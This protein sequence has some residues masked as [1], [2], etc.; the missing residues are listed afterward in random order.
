MKEFSHTAR[1]MASG[2]LSSDPNFSYE[3]PF[4]VP[5]LLVRVTFLECE[6][7]ITEFDRSKKATYS[8]YLLVFRAMPDDIYVIVL[9][10]RPD[11]DFKRPVFFNIKK[12][13]IMALVDVVVPAPFTR[14]QNIQPL[15]FSIEPFLNRHSK[16]YSLLPDSPSAFS[17]ANKLDGEFSIVGMDTCSSLL[18]PNFKF[19]PLIHRFKIEFRE[20]FFVRTEIKRLYSYFFRMMKMILSFYPFSRSLFNLIFPTNDGTGALSHG[21]P[22]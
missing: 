10:Q 8:P 6:T 1:I 19:W 15:R 16:P 13:H 22:S 4:A 21:K 12:Q 18:Y 2:S 11:F 3:I 5:R 20:P 9:H 7:L 14:I 17:H